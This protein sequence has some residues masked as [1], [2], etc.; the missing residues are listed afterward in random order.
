MLVSMIF[1]LTLSGCS[2]AKDSGSASEEEAPTV[3]WLSPADG[4]TVAAGDVACSVLIEGFT[5]HDPAKHNDGAPIGYIS[6]S[7]DGAEVLATGET[8]F[9]LPL[10]AGA[11]TLTASLFYSDGDEVLASAD[12]L[13]GED[14]ADAAC[15]PVAA[16][17][18]VTAE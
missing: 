12:H 11:H 5:L 14:D 16:S 8:T 18:S 15:V 2:G 9:T 7:A 17:I 6:V 13:C 1:A 4:D 10:A 3:S